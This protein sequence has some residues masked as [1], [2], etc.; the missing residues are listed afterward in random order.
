MKNSTQVKRAGVDL[1]SHCAGIM[2]RLAAN[3]TA[4]Q[5]EALAEANKVKVYPKPLRNDN[6]VEWWNMP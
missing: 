2:D 6:Q 3:L 1:Q 4:E 5:Q